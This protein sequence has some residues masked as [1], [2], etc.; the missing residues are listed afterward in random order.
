MTW[1][2]GSPVCV[3][4]WLL[5]TLFVYTPLEAWSLGYKTECLVFLGV[6]LEKPE[7]KVSQPNESGQETLVS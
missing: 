7:T 5:I 4:Y 2:I 1:P 3:S 6:D